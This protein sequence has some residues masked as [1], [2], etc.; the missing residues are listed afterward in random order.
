MQVRKLNVEEEFKKMHSREKDKKVIGTCLE[1]SFSRVVVYSLRVIF[2]IIV[3][4]AGLEL[5]YFGIFQNSI[6]L[7][8]E[9][10]LLYSIL[11]FSVYLRIKKKVTPKIMIFII[12]GLGLVLRIIWA[13][14]IESI[15]VSDFEMA[16][17]AAL[18]IAMGDYSDMMGT[19]Y[20][21][22]F[23]HMTMLVLFFSKMISIFGNNSLTAIRAVNIIFSTSTIPFIYLICKEIFKDDNRAIIGSF[24]AAIMPASI[25]YTSVYCSENLAIPFY[26]ASVYCFILVI[27]EKSKERLLIISGLILMIGHLFRM[28]AQI[29]VISYVMYILIYRGKDYLKKIKEIGYILISFIIPFIIIGNLLVNLGITD[30]WLWNG[31]EPYITSILKGSN[32][33]HFGRWNEEDS[34]FIEKNIDDREYLVAASKEKIIDRYTDNSP[35]KVGGFFL[36]KL[37]MQWGLGDC[38]ASF[39]SESNISQDKVKIDIWNKGSAWYQLFYLILLVLIIKGLFNKKEYL[40]NN[41]INL[42]YIIFC[43]YGITFLILEAQERYAF[44]VYWIF[45]ILP[46]TAFSS[47]L[48]FYKINMNQL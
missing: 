6:A 23:P 38:L 7:N 3:V 19:A 39:L 31:S 43:G 13:F 2:A 10:I 17:K 22:R 32:I 36:T 48:K 44:I 18:N 46:L 25:L 34:K 1:K 35:F 5:V 40:E 11:S 29:V 8:I 33:E 16:Y 37:A 21:G 15:P 30:R 26:L 14:S 9:L 24:I 47:D 41:I 27:N 12:I 20:F 28:V 4:G 42:F 45:V